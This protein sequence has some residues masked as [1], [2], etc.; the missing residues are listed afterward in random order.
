[1]IDSLWGLVFGTLYG[2]FIMVIALLGAIPYGIY[3]GFKKLTLRIRGDGN[4]DART[5]S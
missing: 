2:S 1:M 5:G 4:G 3:Q